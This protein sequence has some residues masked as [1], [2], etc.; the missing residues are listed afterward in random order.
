MLHSTE[1][2]RRTMHSAV[3]ERVLLGKC[4]EK[5]FFCSPVVGRLVFEKNMDSFNSD[6]ALIRV[7]SGVS[8]EHI[9]DDPRTVGLVIVGDGKT[10]V[11]SLPSIKVTELPEECVG[12]IALLDPCCGRLFI[13]PDISTLNKYLPHF[14]Q[15]QQEKL[16]TFIL[17]D[18][19]KL[20]LS[21]IRD[22][23]NIG[24]EGDSLIQFNVKGE[25][26]EELYLKCSALTENAVGR[27]MTLMLSAEDTSVSTLRALMRSAVWG[28][29]SL[30]LCG[31]LSEN[32]LTDI[33]KKYCHAFCDLESDGREFNGYIPRGLCIDSPYLLSLSHSLRGVDFF[34]YDAERLTSLFCNERNTPPSTAI[35]YVL[36][37]IKNAV[38]KRSDIWHGVIL[39]DR[40]LSNEF[41]NELKDCGIEWYATRTSHIRK[42][43]SSL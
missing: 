34:I 30:L 21:M 41:C 33:M 6:S 43:I 26:E 37:K 24:D 23:D 7:T 42:L 5:P 8:D 11:V 18:G 29:L 35:L 16:P 17:R 22:E 19:K 28:E 13:S 2:N 36:S 14:F 15:G 9:N 40:T 1:H 12:R 38:Q 39:G 10:G 31:I 4:E 25:N 20:S 3:G 32:E 27:R